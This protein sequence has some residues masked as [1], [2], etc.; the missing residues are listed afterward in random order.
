MS[1]ANIRQTESGNMQIF[2]AI[3]ADDFERVKAIIEKDPS[4]VNAVA[5]KRPLDTRGMSPLQVSLCTGR[6]KRIAWLLLESGADV[7]Y[8]PDKKL[9]EE[10]HPVLFDGVNAAIWNARRYAW[11][12]KSTDPLCLEWKHTKEES[13]DAFNFLKRMLEL[14]ADVNK[15]DHYGRNCLMEAV[16]ETSNLC[17]VKNSETGEYYPGRP[18]TPEMCED[19]RRILK[20]LIDVGADKNNISSYSKKSIREHYENES[21]WQ[22]CGEFW[23][24]AE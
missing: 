14:G 18:I 24:K 13:D 22:I 9:V 2:D 23:E 21:V 8:I 16:A 1:K 4:A 6:H 17:P 15:T 10:A 19:I 3:R 5:P 11:D 12:G 20:L 7:N